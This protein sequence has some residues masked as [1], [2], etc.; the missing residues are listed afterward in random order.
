MSIKKSLLAASFRS[1]KALNVICV[2]REIGS[3]YS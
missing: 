2:A 1:K 3:D